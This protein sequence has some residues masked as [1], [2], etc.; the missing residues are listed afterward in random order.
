[1]IKEGYYNNNFLYL[2]EKS[3]RQTGLLIME[4]ETDMVR[5]FLKV[6]LTGL[7]D[8]SYMRKKGSRLTKVLKLIAINE[9]E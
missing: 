8:I 5:V 2:E 9:E 4:I 3:L 1:M 6:K 7:A